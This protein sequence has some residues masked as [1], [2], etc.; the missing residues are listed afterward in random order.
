[1]IGGHLHA[2]PTVGRGSSTESME[3]TRARRAATAT[4]LAE[5][6]AW[7]GAVGP[8]GRSG[9]GRSCSR[10]L[11]GDELTPHRRAFQLDPMG[12]VNDAVEDRVT[13]R[14]VGDDLVPF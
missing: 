13:E 2:L 5:R 10:A 12:A 14:G 8:H 7:G 1:M 11:G 6:R 4:S 9:H 3:G